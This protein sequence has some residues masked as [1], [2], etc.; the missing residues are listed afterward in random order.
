LKSVNLIGGTF[1]LSIIS[2][3]LN[4]IV[5]DPPEKGTTFTLCL[6][7]GRKEVTEHETI[8]S[9]PSI[10]DQVKNELLNEMD[11]S[12]STRQ[13][14]MKNAPLIMIVEDNPDVRFYISEHL[15]SSFQIVEANDGK[16]GLKCAIKKIPDLIISD[17][18]MPGMDGFELCHHLKAD[19]R[20]SHIPVILLTA[21][22]TTEDKIDGLETGA[23]DYLT[24]PFDA[25]ELKVR[26]RN[27]I[28]QREKLHEYYS[29]HLNF[30]HRKQTVNT[31]NQT[32][33][34][35]AIDVVERHLADEKYNVSSFSRDMAY[36]PSQLTRKLEALTGL[37]PSRFIRVQRLAQ[38]G[39]MLGQ[40]EV[41][42]SQVAYEC[43]FNNLSYFSR[44]FKEQF[45][46]SPSEYI[47]NLS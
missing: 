40:G 11:T 36:S 21:R 20:T 43:G 13:K 7:E 8:N 14:N 15:E 37:S 33:F 10:S 41:N 46:Q 18:M 28:R 34:N 35:R 4:P 25:E 31:A 47:K 42:I 26:I 24:K 6:P 44:S 29:T 23:D 17:V 32:F 39:K 2:S 22:A 9:L 30:D 16:A 45:G 27:L 3:G 38:A 5:R 1:L 12:K 19:E